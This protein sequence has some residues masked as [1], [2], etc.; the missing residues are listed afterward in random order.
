MVSISR[1]AQLSEVGCARTHEPS[2]LHPSTARL[3]LA[4]VI[5]SSATA[6]AFLRSRS[7]HRWW[8]ASGNITRPARVACA[9]TVA[10]IWHLRSAARAEMAR[11]AAERAECGRRGRR[12]CARRQRSRW[13]RRQPQR[14]RRARGGRGNSA[15]VGASSDR[16]PGAGRRIELAGVNL[17]AKNQQVPLSQPLSDHQQ[18]SRA[19][20]QAS[21]RDPT[22]PRPTPRR[23][24]T[25]GARRP[26]RAAQAHE[27]KRRAKNGNSVA[28]G[29]RVP[30][31]AP[32]VQCPCP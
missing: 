21:K 3:L 30:A 18:G 25:P 29:P 5:A 14:V 11:A 26:A 8:R 27:K 10:E 32:H 23:G 9:T 31:H 7:S 19:S 17:G 12:R 6:L 22:S 16:V 1:R 4:R 13:R 24:A 28:G 15:A 2:P 20:K